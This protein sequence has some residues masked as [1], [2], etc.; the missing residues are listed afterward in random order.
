ML[1]SRLGRPPAAG[2]G[3]APGAPGAKC[4]CGRNAPRLVA[5]IA[6]LVAVGSLLAACGSTAQ[7]Q[8]R[9]LGPRI[10]LIVGD[11]LPAGPGTGRQA[12]RLQKAAQLAVGEINDEVGTLGIDHNLEIVHGGARPAD[13]GGAART[14]LADRARCLIGAQDAAATRRV[15]QVTAPGAEALLISPTVPVFGMPGA[16]PGLAVAMPPLQAANS[17]LG[18]VGESASATFAR[19]YASSG[20]KLGLA[21]APEA[22]R[23][24]AVLACYLAAVAAGSPRPLRLAGRIGRP[25][26]GAPLLPWT[27]LDQAILRLA[28]GK[29]ITYAGVTAK[30]GIRPAGR[31]R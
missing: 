16:E 27:Q 21:R 15:A 22:R 24:D 14:L 1:R 6:I 13:A 8:P 20:E 9:R 4:A 31:G 30:L 7:D 23:F 10:S 18:V 29:P 5:S 12:A 17:P 28:K 19:L 25:L 2:V 3:P 26:R 11:L